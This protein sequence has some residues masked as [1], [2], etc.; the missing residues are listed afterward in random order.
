MPISPWAAPS[1]VSFY[2]LFTNCLAVSDRKKST[3]MTAVGQ[4]LMHGNKS[5]TDSAKVNFVSFLNEIEND[6][7][8]TRKELNFAKNEVKIL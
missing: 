1:H 4:Q 7:N 5:N 6:I 2:N 3:V 8:E